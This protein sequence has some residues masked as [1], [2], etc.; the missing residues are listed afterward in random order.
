M[1]NNINGSSGLPGESEEF[2]GEDQWAFGYSAAIRSL[3]VSPNTQV[4]CNHASHCLFY[5][6]INTSMINSSFHH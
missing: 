1:D 6:H 3:D 2:L 4:Y 5:V